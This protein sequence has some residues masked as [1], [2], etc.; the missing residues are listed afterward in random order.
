MQTES[1]RTPFRNIRRKSIVASQLYQVYCVTMNLEQRKSLYGRWNAMKQRCNNPK[2]PAWKS[3]G[4]RGITVC[5]RWKNSFDAFVSDMGIPGPDLCLDRINNNGNYEPGN[6]RWATTME[7][8]QNTTTL[9]RLT[10]NGRTQHAAA[11]ER[12]TGIDAS[13]IIWRHDH[14]LPD[15]E[16]LDP[17]RVRKTNKGK[18]FPGRRTKAEQ[19]TA[20]ESAKKALGL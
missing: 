19:Q 13:A 10:I 20:L 15:S 4:A 11:W 12:E 14:G 3:Y 2:N 16:I 1:L 6:C 9:R 18:T 8:G 17:N 7:S 5:D